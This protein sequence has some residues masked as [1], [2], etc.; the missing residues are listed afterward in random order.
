MNLYLG[1]IRLAIFMITAIKDE[2][3]VQMQDNDVLVTINYMVVL[4]YMNKYVF[5]Y[6][7]L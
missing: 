7:W 3:F 6:V 5:F 1:D 2:K 4:F